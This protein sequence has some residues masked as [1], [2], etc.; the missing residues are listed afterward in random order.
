MT[1]MRQWLIVLVFSAIFSVVINSI[2]FGAMVN[3]F[4]VDYSIENY[5]EHIA[6][7]VAFSNIALQDAGLTRRQMEV[8][9]ETHLQDPITR[10]RLYNHSGDL[11]ADVGRDFIPMG[12]MMS[13]RMMRFSQED[14]NEEIDYFEVGEG[15]SAIG[16]LNVTRYSSIG[17]SF[18]SRQFAYSLVVSSLISFVIVLGVIIVLGTFI[19]RRMSRDLRYTANLALDIELG[20]KK[21]FKRSGVKEIRTIQQSLEMLDSRLKLKHKSRKRIIDEMIHQTRTPLT[22]IRAH[23]EGFEDGIV[24]FDD[25]EIKT[26]IDQVEAITSIVSNMSEV[27]DTDELS[28]KMVF[29]TFDIGV[30]MKQ[31]VDGFRI[32]YKQKNVALTLKSTQKESI[33]SDRNKLSQVIYNL[34]SNA[35]KYTRPDDVVVVNYEVT[36][37]GFVVIKVTDSGIGISE[38]ELTRVFEPYYRG[39][40]AQSIQGDGIG[41]YIAYEN[42][43][44][45]GGTITVNSK[46]GQ[47]T[48]FT[49]TLPQKEGLND[50]KV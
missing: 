11:I 46:L 30:M 13:N 37:D 29:E 9:L 2:L 34:L 27:L 18:K 28:E 12:G 42:I 35:Y 16:F 23:L 40:N 6:Q 36:I 32:Q 38:V 48:E 21:G 8:Q 31:I 24:A 45:M 47:G 26:C 5:K 43:T 4:F 41:L 22:I 7:V 39:E 50:E 19:S 10:I 49:I 14:Y 20:H 25:V 1:V 15:D 33:Y 3:R 44:K 17:E